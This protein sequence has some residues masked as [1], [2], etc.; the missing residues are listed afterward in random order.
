MDSQEVGYVLSVRGSLIYANGLPT[1]KIMDV[2]ENE[3]GIRGAISGLKEDNVEIWL[4]DE[5][6]VVPG[7]LFKKSQKKLTIPISQAILGRAINPLGVPIDNK[8]QINLTE[9]KEFEFERKK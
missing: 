1:V 8:G 4:M 6:M 3:Q 2:V 9:S 7:Q 5:G